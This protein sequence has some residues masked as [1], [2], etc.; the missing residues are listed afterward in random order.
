MVQVLERLRQQG[1]LPRRFLTDNG[2]EFTGH[3]LN[4][5]AQK[6]G[7][8]L[9]HSRPGKPTDN[10]FVESFNGRQRDECL[11]QNIFVSLSEAPHIIEEWGQD[12]NCNRPTALW[13]AKPGSFPG[14]PSTLNN[15]RNH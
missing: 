2:P 7:L 6:Y 3:A 9:A 13:V 8:G 11:N 4:V 1:R 12:Y 5:W 14:D 10:G 15:D